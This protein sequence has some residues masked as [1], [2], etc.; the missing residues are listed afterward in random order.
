MLYNIPLRRPIYPPN[1]VSRKVYYSPSVYEKNKKDYRLDGID[2]MVDRKRVTAL[3]NHG[4]HAY[5][6]KPYTIRD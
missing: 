6:Q 4:I 3:D 5:A 2:T 1:L